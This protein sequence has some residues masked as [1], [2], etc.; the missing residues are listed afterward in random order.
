MTS[1]PDHELDSH[2]R[3]TLERVLRHPAGG[4]VEWREVRSLLESVGAVEERDG[5]LRVALGG[6][7]EV[8]HRPHGKDVDAQTIVDLRRM[9]ERAG[10]G[11]G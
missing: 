11:G 9:F 7:T 2:Q 1:S 3:D 6:E 10:F 4:N 8:F 5:A